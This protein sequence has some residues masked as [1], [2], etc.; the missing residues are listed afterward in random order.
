MNFHY[1]PILGLQYSYSQLILQIDIEAMPGLPIDE[2][3]RL[4]NQQGIM[5]ADDLE[6][7]KMHKH[8]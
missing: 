2:A 7:E 8:N 1:H 4:F 5:L 6:L 3:L